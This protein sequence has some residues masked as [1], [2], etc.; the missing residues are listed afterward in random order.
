MET[1]RD[2]LDAGASKFVVRPMCPPQE[3]IEQ[4]ELFGREIVPHFHK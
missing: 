1:I 2:F 4:F 3:A